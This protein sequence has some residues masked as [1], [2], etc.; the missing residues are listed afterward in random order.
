[1]YA[2]ENKGR[3]GGKLREG[4][5]EERGRETRLGTTSQA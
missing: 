2:G 1:M 3:R 5:R 4:R